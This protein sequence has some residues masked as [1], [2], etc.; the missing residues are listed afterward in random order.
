MGGSDRHL[1]KS[2]PLCSENSIS[3]ETIK[4]KI[5]AIR[6]KGKK[7]QFRYLSPVSGMLSAAVAYKL[8]YFARL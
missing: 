2:C 5:C 7:I 8:I 4:I 1:K 3:G 6:S